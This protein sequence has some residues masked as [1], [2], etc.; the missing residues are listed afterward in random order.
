VAGAVD[1]GRLVDGYGR[2]HGDLLGGLASMM[3]QSMDSYGVGSNGPLI[4]G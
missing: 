3:G 2:R 1:G 4:L